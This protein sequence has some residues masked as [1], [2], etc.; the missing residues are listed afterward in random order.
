MFDETFPKMAR[1]AYSLGVTICEYGLIR[2]VRCVTR[3]AKDIPAQLRHTVGTHFRPTHFL[4]DLDVLYNKFMSLESKNSIFKPFS[5]IASSSPALTNAS[6][7]S[8]GWP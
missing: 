8:Q 2:S 1:R 3:K 5:L 4:T 6:P 7:C